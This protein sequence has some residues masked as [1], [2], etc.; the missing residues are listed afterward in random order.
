[1]DRLSSALGFVSLALVSWIMTGNIS[2][3]KT[4]SERPV[5]VQ[6]TVSPEITSLI[7][8]M[9]QSMEV[10]SNK[11]NKLDFE[12]ADPDASKFIRDESSW[13]PKP[14]STSGN[15]S[16]GGI[17]ASS[18]QSYGSNGGYSQPVSSVS[19]RDSF[20]SNG[21]YSAARPQQQYSP[22]LQRTR[23]FQRVRSAPVCVDGSCS[24]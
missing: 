9:N 12:R 15:G 18:V 21:G 1:M 22:A 14:Q 17:P 23:L 4:E 13:A 19:Y 10:M 7:S 2:E 3:Q 16:T 20:G 6:S 24:F 11:F 5:I 8:K